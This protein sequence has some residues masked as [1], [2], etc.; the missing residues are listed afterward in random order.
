ME[1]TPSRQQ[2]EEWARQLGIIVSTS[3]TEKTAPLA[4]DNLSKEE[5]FE[6]SHSHS[7]QWIKPNAKIALLD[8]CY[9]YF[10]ELGK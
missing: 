6:I 7:I 1:H 10:L 4:L 9:Q 2:V 8:I 5:C 3:E